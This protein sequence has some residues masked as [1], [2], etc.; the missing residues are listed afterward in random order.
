MPLL[1]LFQER[2]QRQA[3]EQAAEQEAEQQRAA[4][5]PVSPDPGRY[6]N[7][8]HKSYG[9][10]IL[11]AFCEVSHQNPTQAFPSVKARPLKFKE[12]AW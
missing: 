8:Q 11:F 12:D 5:Y 2:L 4:M 3:E 9:S 7:C 10:L 1:Y 6:R